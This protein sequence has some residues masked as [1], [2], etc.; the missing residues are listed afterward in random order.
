MFKKIY[1]GKVK[2][3]LDYEKFIEDG[4]ETYS[5]VKNK[6]GNFIIAQKNVRT[7]DEK[8]VLRRILRDLYLYKR[9][10]SYIFLSNFPKKNGDMYVDES[11]LKKV[12]RKPKTKRLKN[13]K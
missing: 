8:T 6:N 2:K 9:K 5:D 13:N 10:S 11:T 7:I 4:E 3:C 1:I 12:V